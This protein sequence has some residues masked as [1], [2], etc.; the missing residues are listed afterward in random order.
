VLGKPSITQ[1][2]RLSRS[3]RAEREKET[4][5]RRV[6]EIFSKGVGG[7]FVI[8]GRGLRGVPT[9]KQGVKQAVTVAGDIEQLHLISKF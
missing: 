4:N 1:S 5:G 3:F 9:S 2:I 6:R 8:R 7:L